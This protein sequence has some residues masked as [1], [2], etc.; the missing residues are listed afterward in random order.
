LKAVENV[1]K[2]IFDAVVWKDFD[3][4]ISFE[5]TIIDLDGTQN[6]SKLG[7]N[8][9]LACGMAYAQADAIKNWKRLYEYLWD[10]NSS[11]MPV[12]YMN[13]INGG[14]HADNGLDFQEFMIIPQWASSFREALRMWAEVFHTLKKLLKAQWLATSVWDEWW[15]APN[16]RSNREALD[17]VIKAIQQAWYN[18]DQIKIWLDVASTEFF[19]DWKYDISGEWKILTPKE[20]AQYYLDLIKD[21]PIV[22]I[23][24]WFAEDDFEWRSFFESVNPG[25]RTVWDD[26]YV[27]NVQRLQ[28][29][30]EQK[31]SNSILIKLNQIWS[32]TETLKTIKSAHDNNMHS[33]ISHRSWESEDTFIAD[34]AVAV[35]SWYIKT[36]SLSR[37]DRIAKYNQLLRIEEKLWSKA[38]FGK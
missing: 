26:L 29:W 20:M 5:K 23:E 22:S 2:S 25:I 10:E 33:I 19:K 18:T 15:Y 7:A 13:I 3:S 32:V 9:I 34:L 21:Y 24:D 31:L 8:A 17:L 37:T 11:V 28:Q 14:A 12:P 1:N 35:N 4:L 36:G 6:K 38:K 27:T 16:I 30:I